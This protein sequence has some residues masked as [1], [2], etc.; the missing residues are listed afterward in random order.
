M[1]KALSDYTSLYSLLLELLLYVI[2]F[3][4]EVDSLLSLSLVNRLF[5]QL[6]TPYVFKTLKIAFLSARLDCLV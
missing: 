2:N 4:R 5:R 6:Y 1:A 3:T